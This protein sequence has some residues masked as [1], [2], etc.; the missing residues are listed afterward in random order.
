MHV[1]GHHLKDNHARTI[2]KQKS[3][4]LCADEARAIPD[5]ATTFAFFHGMV[6]GAVTYV[7]PDRC[8]LRTFP[9]APRCGKVA[10]TFNQHPTAQP[11]NETTA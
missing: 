5:T 10:M 1:T 2:S 8:S 11:Y 9:N 3:S 6:L 4:A 7:T